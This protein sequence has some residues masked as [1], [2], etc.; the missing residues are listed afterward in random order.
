MIDLNK[1]NSATM[2]KTLKE[3]IRGEPVG[4]RE[5]ENVDF[6]IIGDIDKCNIAD[7]FNLY[8][9][10]NIDSIV[11]S[12]KIDRFGSNIIEH[13]INISKKIIYIIENKGIMEDFETVKLEQLEKVILGLLKKKDTEEGII[14]DILKAAFSVIKKE[15]ANK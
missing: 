14:S 4:V 5:V 11:N 2:W 13:W 15:F 12:I 7:K 9:I 10:Q 3:I 8:Y 1:E 6:E